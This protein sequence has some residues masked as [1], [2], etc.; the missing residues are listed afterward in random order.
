[1]TTD[2]ISELLIEAEENGVTVFLEEGKLKFSLDREKLSDE[3][4]IDRLR[5]SKEGIFS[6]LNAGGLLLGAQTHAREALVPFDRNSIEKIPLSFSQER[7]W[8]IHQFEGSIAYHMPAVLRV[9][10]ALNVPAL[11]QAF[12]AIIDRHEILRTVIKEEKGHAY[13][14]VLS[15]DGWHLGVNEHSPQDHDISLLVNQPFDLSRDFMLRADVFRL[16]G[17]EHILVLVLHHIAS[18]GWSEGILISELIECYQAAKENRSFVLPALRVQ[19]ADYAMW[20]RKHLS[21]DFLT[22]RLAYWKEKLSNTTPLV[23]PTDF[24]KTISKVK[25]GDSVTV[26]VNSSLTRQL[27][28][29]SSSHDS[30]LFM[31]LLS[32]LNILLSRYSGQTDICIGSPV[33]NRLQ[34]EIAPL[35]GFFVNTLVFRNTVSAEESFV[36]LLG[37]VRENALEAHVHQDT[38]F[39]KVIDALGIERN[40]G[41]NPVFEVLFVLNEEDPRPELDGGELKISVDPGQHKVSQ[42]DL[43]FNIIQ[44]QGRLKINIEY[45]SD[46]FRADTIERMASHFQELL[47]SVANSPE[48]PVAALNM[49]TDREKDQLLT[50]EKTEVNYSEDLTIVDEFEAVVLK[51]GHRIGLV[52]EDREWTYD[53]LNEVS[54][55]LAWYLI[56]NYQLQEEDLVSVELPR[57]EWTV[58]TILAILKAGSA[59]V[60]I[61]LINPEERIRFM[62]EDSGCKL[63]INSEEI[64]RFEAQKEHLSRENPRLTISS[65]S[66]AYVIYTSGSTGKP[67]GVVIEH[68]NLV[69][70][71]RFGEQSSDFSPEDTWTMFHS[72]SFDLSVMEMFGALLFG[73]KLVVVGQEAA[74]NTH[75]FLE[76][77]KKHKISVICQTPSAFYNLIQTEVSIPADL[78]HLRYVI[79][80][81]EALI[82]DRLKAWKE[83]YPQIRFS[84]RYGPTE[85]TLYVTTKELT[86]EDLDQSTSNIGQPFPTRQVYILD[87]QLGL[88][89]TGVVGELHLGGAGLARCYLNRPELTAERFIENP[90]GDGRLY[91]TGDLA[92]RLENGDVEYMGRKD[93]QVK[94]RGYRIELGEIENRLLLHSS[95]DSVIVTDQEP[96]KSGKQLVAYVV[97]KQGFNEE[98]LS[99][100]LLKFLP[101]YMVPVVWLQ[102]DEIP[103][104]SNGKVNRHLL[105]SPQVQSGKEYVAPR[106]AMETRL[107]S[108]WEQ[109]LGLKK[110]G[111]HDNFFELGGDSIISIQIISLA[112][113]LGIGLGLKDLFTHQTIASLALVTRSIREISASQALLSGPAPL[114]PIQHQ[115]FQSNREQRWHYNQSVLLQVPEEIEAPVLKKSLQAILEHHDSLRFYYQ[116]SN[117]QWQQA[118]GQMPEHIPFFTEEVTDFDKAFQARLDHWQSSLDLKK[119]QLV[120][121]VLFRTK[122]EARL[123]WCIHHLSVDGVSWRILL[124]DLS[125][126][127][128]SLIKETPFRFAT[129]TSSFGDWASSIWS[130]I[131]TPEAQSESYWR[132]IPNSLSELPV[133]FEKEGQHVISPAILKIELDERRTS[134]LLQAIHSYRLGVD[135]FLMASLLCALKAWSGFEEYLIDLESHGRVSKSED[136]DISR[137]V[138]WFT[139]LY[140]AHFDISNSDDIDTLLKTVKEQMR[141]VPDEGIG[142]GLLSQQGKTLPKGCVLFNYLGQFK[143]H[144]RESAIEIAKEPLGQEH[145][146]LISD[147][148]LEIN[149]SIT[150]GRLRLELAY[151]R[152]Q[153]EDSTIEFFRI[154]FQNHLDQSIRHCQKSYG[155]SPSDFP[156][157]SVLQKELDQLQET[158]ERNIQ[159]IYPLSFMQEGILFHSLKNEEY[160]PYLIQLQFDFKIEIDL[161]LFEKTWQKVTDRHG[162]FRTA[163]VLTESGPLQVQLEKV[164]FNLRV[165]QASNED[166]KALDELTKRLKLLARQEL[167]QL[168]KAP[169]LR[170]E[171][172]Q[173]DGG[174]YHMIWHIHHSIIDGWST[175]ILS[176]EVLSIY[177]SLVKGEPIEFSPQ[178]SF[179]DYIKWLSAKDKNTAY[180]YW[181]DKLNDF[182]TPTEVTIG[183]RANSAGKY[184]NISLTVDTT[185]NEE[186]KGMAQMERFTMNTIV[187]S[188]WSILLGR[189][190]NTTDI[191]FGVTNSG[192]QVPVKGIEEMIGLFI[193]TLPMRVQLQEKTVREVCE[194]IQGQQQDD[195]QNGHVRLSDI[196]KNIELGVDADL[197]ETIVVFENYPVS[198]NDLVDLDTSLAGV[199][200]EESNNYPLTLSAGLDEELK[201][202]LIY[203]EGRFQVHEA[204]QILS[205]L[206]HILKGMT[207]NFEA[208][209]IELPVL[210]E[211]E[212]AEILSKQATP[213]VGALKGDTIVDLFEAQVASQGDR[214]ALLFGNNQM[215]YAEL[216]ELSNQMAWYLLKEYQVTSEDLISIELERSEWVVIAILGILKAGAAYVPID[217]VYPKERVS[218]M[219]EDSNCRVRIN[220]AELLRFRECSESFS[221]LNPRIDFDA[222]SA[223]Y[224]IYT[225]G[226]SGQPK[227]VVIEHKNVVSLLRPDHS[228]FSFSEKD[229]WVLFHSYS[230]DF[231]VWEMFGALLF[232]AKLIIIDE[233]T[234]R[235]T[236]AFLEILKN[237]E[238]TVLNQTPSAFY[239]L[240]QLEKEAANRV[241]NLRYVVFG[242]EALTVNQLADWKTRYPHTRLINMY[243]ITETTVHVTF[244]E[245]G[246]E[247]LYRVESNIGR[248]I[249]GW[250]CYVLND[251]LELAPYGVVGE[252]YVGGAG[253][254][255]GYLDR[256][257]LTTERFVDHPFGSGLLY[258]TGDLAKHLTNGDLQYMGR[259]D[260]QVKIR[261]YR[262]ELGEIENLLQEHASVEQV[263][264][265]THAFTQDNKQ[266]TAYVVSVGAFDQEQLETYLADHLPQYMIPVFWVPLDRIPMTANGKVNKRSLP[267]PTAGLAGK[268]TAPRS[269]E[270]SRLAVIWQQ[271]L[272]RDSMG[273][274]DDFFESGGDS[275]LVIRL[276]GQIQKEFGIK[277]KLGLIYQYPTIAELAQHMPLHEANGYDP[278]SELLKWVEKDLDSL[279]M[280]VM[281]KV[282]GD[283]IEDAYPMVD[284]QKGMVFHALVEKEFGVYHDQNA[285]TVQ[286]LDLDRL[287]KALELMTAKH[288]ILRT[289]FNVDDY[290]E[291]VQL[292]YKSVDIKLEYHDITGLKAGTQEQYVLNYL[293]KQRNKPFIL[294]K[295]PLWRMAFLKTAPDQ[296]VLVLEVHHAILDGWSTASFETELVHVYRK[297]ES[298]PGYIPSLLKTDYR[299]YVIESKIDHYRKDET[300]AF[301]KEELSGYSKPQVFNDV[302]CQGGR[303]LRGLVDLDKVN[304]TAKDLKVSPKTVFLGAYIH[305]MSKLSYES[306]HIIG[307]VSNSRPLREDGD[308]ILGCFLNTIPLR[309]NPSTES[310]SWS[311]FLRQIER[312]QIELKGKARMSL[313]DIARTIGDSSHNPLTD[314]FFNY[315]DFHIYGDLLNEAETDPLQDIVQNWTNFYMDLTIDITNGSMDGV[316]LVRKELRSGLS[317]DFILGY[318][319][320]ILE[321]IMENPEAV[322][323]QDDLYPKKTNLE[324]IGQELANSTEALSGANLVALFESQAKVRANEIALSFKEDQWTYQELN[325]WS[326]QLARY[327]KEQHSIG[328]NDFVTVEFERNECMI[329]SLLA[330]LKA[331]GAYVPVDPDY[332]EQRKRYLLNDS[333]SKAHLNLEMFR[334]FEASR[335]KYSKENLTESVHP[336]AAA[337]VIYTSGSTGQPKGVIVEH[338]SVVSLLNNSKGLFNFSSTDVWGFFH[339]FC[340]DVSV[341]EIFGAFSTGG[342]LVVIDDTTLRDPDA[343][344][345]LLVKHQITVANQ[346]P[347]AFFNFEL[348]ERTH[349]ERR[350]R[351]RYLIL[352][353]EALFPG[354]L[355]AWHDRYPETI[356]F[357]AYG[358]TEASIYATYKRIDTQDILA[359]VCNI[360]QPIPNSACFVLDDQQNLLPDGVAGELF[361]G[362]PGVARGY[363][364]QPELTENS[365]IDNP[366]GR[367]RLY[368]SSDHVRRLPNGDLE[369]IGRRDNQLKIR[370]YRIELGEIESVLNLHP[371]VEQAVVGT[372]EASD[373]QSLVGYVTSKEDLDT[374]QLEEYLKLHLPDYMVPRIWMMLDALPLN[375]NGKV[376]RKSLPAPVITTKT[377]YQAPRTVLEKQLS[378]IWQQVL[379]MDRIG[380]HDDFFALGGT[381]LSIM[382]LKRLIYQAIGKTLDIA[383]MMSNPTIVG[384]AERIEDKPA[385]ELFNYELI[386]TLRKTGK[387]PP[388]FFLPGLGG[389]G[390]YFTFLAISLG[391]QYP[392]YAINSWVWSREEYP[393]SLS[394][395]AEIYLEKIRTICPDRPLV[396][397]GHSSGGR[398]AFE[399]ARLIE[400]R[401]GKVQHVLLLD[402]YLL[403]SFKEESHIQDSEA[404]FQS[405]WDFSYVV[406]QFYDL[407]M[408]ISEDEMR[409]MIAGGRHHQ[410][411]A[412]HVFSLLGVVDVQDKEYKLVVDAMLNGFHRERINDKNY[413]AQINHYQIKAPVTLFKVQDAPLLEEE[414]LN[415]LKKRT[416]STAR[417]CQVRGGH[418]TMLQAQYA[419]DLATVIKEVLSGKSLITQEAEV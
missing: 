419:D 389:H 236:N 327:L 315:V 123:L 386:T 333:G 109:V 254:A 330:V 318:F 119:G 192:R 328:A 216:N 59:Y 253:L 377:S 366:F 264:V 121:M 387:E 31:T 202:D 147:Y 226:S 289:A 172:I 391:S 249:P 336:S 188:A 324:P 92:R 117:G 72:Y 139:S 63:R 84:N 220:E 49:L 209:A 343:L 87:E 295:A 96:S 207:T 351:L 135:E 204:R 132:D 262:I 282:Q 276:I 413:L 158:F 86:E 305:M 193:N 190:S 205:H 334:A 149:G 4:I 263:V 222:T 21:G 415:D 171:A 17:Q 136:I 270:E 22:S 288:A 79:L 76:V 348:A 43:S 186:L 404:Y 75:Q 357:N 340:F 166:P 356:I 111:V 42:F 230:F 211:S 167:F 126:A 138:G 271:I 1:M 91:K 73:S 11:E 78:Y 120:K 89:P 180:Q 321:A 19:Y 177:S 355:A 215:T 197:F 70:L 232:G 402:A 97:S 376:D 69:S 303:S 137:T 9:K 134:E 308:K 101:S 233:G 395:L 337:Y 392:C 406:S 323:S 183:N 210:S 335:D 269:P 367:G 159:D 360:G 364:K 331:G 346:T 125:I 113:E 390:F 352:A 342:Q 410:W 302:D 284:I 6:F 213:D 160:D 130:W 301:W 374:R 358:P 34:D 24:T 175:A 296:C 18:D 349:I 345:K 383:T 30:T 115:F 29:L 341:W 359:N 218:F 15:G 279:R 45:R 64:Q 68:K 61:D 291:E 182:D 82:P 81:G 173:L 373:E 375:S 399:L 290:S 16:S 124:E 164:D 326:N 54:N 150:D 95:L 36:Q 8:F 255:R 161:Q 103:L 60:P 267:V 118:Y 14:E 94:I 241:L 214:T 281:E 53:E 181:Q 370:G 272:G 266:L 397:A 38:P 237:Q 85:S 251:Q 217:P 100:H 112:R 260:E 165:H 39:E 339:S 140:S 106:N 239:N 313:V 320:N 378:G 273:I 33:S 309:H 411:L 58:I 32:V 44:V 307:L 365:F 322:V 384:M 141:A 198:E 354:Q 252:L 46:L 306:D 187:Q 145:G 231:S 408:E 393:V 246:E 170:I 174:G 257:E 12:Q 83:R 56:K 312:Q 189:Y 247:D 23:L 155:Y 265:T 65:K 329:V 258:K 199:K 401:G 74:Q 396:L 203:D 235:D 107:V 403:D 297:L 225:S 417:L 261:G 41:Q 51:H 363:L 37:R 274:N 256:P 195:N 385:G 5:M 3:T 347:S 280:E 353:G 400:K 300:A 157:A 208:L 371:A 292:V 287:R 133:D 310:V 229:V 285:S 105:P 40:L 369:Y 50:L 178:R 234:A 311:S 325:E 227:G 361:I 268:Y 238:V 418:I 344:L 28:A 88:L 99:A 286:L 7:L 116:K 304:R 98:T 62:V 148:K 201:L 293:E 381:S 66:A 398:F 228:L 350:L 71:F 104:T 122:T 163:F 362:G 52:H 379:A 142:Y 151:D 299:T 114:S 407:E 184:Q 154:S 48:K 25:A 248:P 90:I 298:N 394:E 77:L 212:K 169:L 200:V 314:V 93:S 153:Y 146:D 275:I 127:Y 368:R 27:K 102:I 131:A 409:E 13:Q 332:P 382:K 156:E 80:G 144:L 194:L 108:V 414:L 168:S 162:I 57:N 412:D 317:L 206:H 388:V 250:Q 47:I 55:Q 179:G 196:Q 240:V 129:K 319:K 2:Q 128:T 143:N 405:C 380:I 219:L 152:A 294:K 242:G 245:L 110:I 176:N 221:K 277:M 243:G 283:E 372:Y 20:Q 416:E 10:G 316:L 223:A 259:K 35:I 338:Q 67:K 26:D 278:E 244:K 224:V 185:L 191:V